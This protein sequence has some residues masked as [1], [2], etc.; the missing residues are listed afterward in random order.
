MGYCKEEKLKKGG[1]GKKKS[2]I[3]ILLFC[4]VPFEIR[5]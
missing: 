4:F 2:H 3:V 1:N 5:Y